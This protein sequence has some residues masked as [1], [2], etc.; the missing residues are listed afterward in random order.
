[1]ASALRK[2]LVINGGQIEQLQAGDILDAPVSDATVL[3]ETNGSGSPI[4][5]GQAVYFNAADSV[6]LAEANAIGTVPCKGLVYAT[7][8]A[9]GSPGAIIME[10]LITLADWSSII[11]S[12]NLTANVPYYLS[13]STAGK[14]TATAPSTVGQYVQEIGF[15]LDTTTM[16]VKPKSTILL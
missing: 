2:P 8:I 3:Q 6:E 13:P 15:A 9:A 1:M 12:A 10:G 11:G 16:F 14:L 7:S 5:Q 4:T